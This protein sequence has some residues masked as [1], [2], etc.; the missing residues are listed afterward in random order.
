MKWV[1][2][3]L[4]ILSVLATASL[5]AGL[6]GKESGT[7][8]VF[9][10]MSVLLLGLLSASLMGLYGILSKLDELVNLQKRKI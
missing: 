6:V 1:F 4:G 7:V 10:E 9:Q 2:L 5:T 3:I 8:T